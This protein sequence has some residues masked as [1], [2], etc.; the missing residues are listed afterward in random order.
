MSGVGAG[1][2]GFSG[3]SSAVMSRSSICAG[4]PRTPRSSL[5]QHRLLRSSLT[6]WQDGD[7]GTQQVPSLLVSLSTVSLGLG[8]GLLGDPVPL[9]GAGDPS[10]SQPGE[11]GFL[12]FPPPR[13][14]WVFTSVSGM[15]GFPAFSSMAEGC[16]RGKE[17][18]E[19]GGASCL[20]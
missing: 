6:D 13:C 9:P 5:S 11:G 14:T 18:E 16:H 17:E 8:R 4:A 19:P 20:C 2:R 12:L 7:S 15:V 1:F 10:W 3:V